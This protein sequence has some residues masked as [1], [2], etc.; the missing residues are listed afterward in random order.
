VPIRKVEFHGEQQE[1]SLTG[2]CSWRRV[3]WGKTS[4]SIKL[5]KLGGSHCSLQ[6][7]ISF[8]HGKK[9]ERKKERLSLAAAASA[10]EDL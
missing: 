5:R 4:S 7:R 8:S 10:A 3:F 1:V 6:R 9:E 2:V